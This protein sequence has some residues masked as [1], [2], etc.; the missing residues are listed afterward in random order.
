[1]YSYLVNG[2]KNEWMNK[3]IVYLIIIISVCLVILLLVNFQFYLIS[4]VFIVIDI[5]T[6]IVTI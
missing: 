6:F 3:W 4:W 5:K 1:M 2:K